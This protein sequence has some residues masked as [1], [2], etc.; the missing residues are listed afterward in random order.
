ML[1]LH[2]AL[3]TLNVSVQFTCAPLLLVLPLQRAFHTVNEIMKSCWNVGLILH[4]D[5]RN[6][7]QFLFVELKQPIMDE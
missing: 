2:C 1:G 4:V 5:W 7:R 6:G 3:F